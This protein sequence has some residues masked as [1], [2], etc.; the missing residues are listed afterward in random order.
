VIVGGGI[1]GLAAAHRLRELRPSLEIV[2]LERGDR[3]GGKIHT[4]PLAGQLCETGA[5]TFL[6]REA[7]EDSKALALA[8]RVGLGDALVHPA[9]VPAALAIHGGLHAIPGGTLMGIPADPADVEGIAKV[10][11]ADRDDGHPLVAPGEDVAVG[12]LVRDRLGEQVVARLVDPLL[13]GVYA[14]RADTLSLQATIPALHRTAQQEP[15]LARAVKAAVASAPRPTGIPIFAT[16]QG[17][18]T[19]FVEAVAKAS[20][21]AVELGTTVK[22]LSA[23]GHGWRVRTGATGRESDVE[24]DAVV[25]AVP[26]RPSARILSTVDATAAEKLAAL[27]YASMALVTL[28]LPAG[29]A[30]PELS[31]FLVPADQGFAVKAATFF[32]TKWPHLA[33]GPV[34]VRA[35]LGR[36]G[37]TSALGLTDEGLV[38][39]VRD[40]L[41]RL[42]GSAL[43]APLMSRTTRWGGGLPQYGVGHVAGVAAV[44]AALP[45]SL[46]LAG[47]A[48][49]GVGIAA[50]VRSGEAAAA[51]VWETLRA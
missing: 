50:C 13:G 12:A 40:E 34:L 29:T 31:G 47:A 35:S 49:D 41:S 48:H 21:A 37:D 16:V 30:L 51:Q 36:Y 32:T 46:A 45:P 24:A 25:L 10:T 27:D 1:A 6:M 19:R 11:G 38:D 17:G 4:L 33:G 18:L 39:L 42:I 43:P 14:G 22:Q 7:G 44:R 2:V 20:D 9:P 28:A 8:R 23:A 3:L 15:T 26:A 5:E